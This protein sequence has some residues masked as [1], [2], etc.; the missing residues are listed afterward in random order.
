MNSKRFETLAIRTQIAK[1]AE[2]EHSAPLYLTSSFLFENAEQA[3][4]MF[5]GEEEGNIY[6]RYSNPN[7][8]ELVE[9]LCLLEGFE[10]G[11]ATSSGM[12][13]VYATIA[14]LLQ[15]GDHLLICRSVFGST[16]QITSQILPKMGIGY[17]YIDIN[18]QDRWEQYAKPETKM[19]LVET[20]TNPGLD[21]VDLEKAS[22]WTKASGI[23]FAVDNCFATPY[24]Q[25]PAKFGADIVTHSGTKFID[26]QG[27]TVGGAILASK[28]II[29]P[30]RFFC[31]QTGPSMSPFNAWVLSK[32]LETLA[33]RMDRH[34]ESAFALATWLIE[35]PEVEEVKHPFLDHHPM[36]EV[37]QKQMKYGGGLVVFFVKGGLERG[38]KF[39]DA[40]EM[41]SLTAN[42]GDSRTIATHPASTTH[43]KL[44][45]EERLEVGIK[46]NLI[47]VSV[48]LEHIED[49]KED[50][51][52]AL[53]KSKA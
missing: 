41:I 47:R 31:R 19:L 2:R 38:R 21:I 14:G 18:D 35:H 30:I 39:L 1:T 10:D 27:R 48:G 34:C 17:T 36:K 22:T 20:P 33:V 9:K 8:N 46:D 40:L 29:S 15:L 4:A 6:S 24:L 43:S 51:D 45:Q 28:E 53:Q 44:T 13:A 49:I 11:V 5:A 32:S 50:I 25:Q 3:R 26:G 12:A 23:L 16:H 52:Q 42:L 37:A 7:T